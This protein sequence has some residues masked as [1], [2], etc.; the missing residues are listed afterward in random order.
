VPLS[1]AEYSEIGLLKIRFRIGKRG[2]D[3]EGAERCGAVRSHA[4]CGRVACYPEEPKKDWNSHLSMIHLI[5]C[6]FIYCNLTPCPNNRLYLLFAICFSR[7]ILNENCHNVVMI[8]LRCE[9]FSGGKLSN[10]AANCKC[11]FLKAQLYAA[12]CSYLLLCC[13]HIRRNDW[14]IFRRFWFYWPT[15]ILLRCV[16]T[17]YKWFPIESWD[18]KFQTP[19]ESNSLMHCRWWGLLFLT[20]HLDSY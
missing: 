10:S 1:A 18:Q 4:Q 2:G 3:A 7:S 17:L 20:V 12:M 8:L 9:S 13:K 19:S 15:H 5:D 14:S 6:C 16:E 11:F